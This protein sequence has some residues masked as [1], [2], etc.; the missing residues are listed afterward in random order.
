VLPVLDH[1]GRRR[2]SVEV[3]RVAV[4]PF[5]ELDEDVVATQGPTRMSLEAWRERQRGFYASCREEV[6]LLLGEPGW[7]LTGSEPMVFVHFGLAAR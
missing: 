2:A 3:I 7:Q 5:D 1:R 6:A 4:V